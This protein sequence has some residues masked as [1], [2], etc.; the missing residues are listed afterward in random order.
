MI[1][2]CFTALVKGTTISCGL[3]LDLSHMWVFEMHILLVTPQRESAD[4]KYPR[5]Q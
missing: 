4:L 3:C 5:E 2:S 1:K